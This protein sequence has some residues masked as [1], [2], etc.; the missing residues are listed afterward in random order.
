MNQY[1]SS[2]S[3]GY[4]S[5]DG[6]SGAASLPASTTDKIQ[7]PC[8]HCHAVLS[9][10]VGLS[11]FQCPRCSSHLSVDHAKLAAYMRSLNEMAASLGG[12]TMAA[13][14]TG[15]TAAAAAAAAAAESEQAKEAESGW[16][17]D[18]LLRRVH[19]YHGRG[20]GDG[21]VWA[22]GD[23]GGCRGGGSLAGLG[24]GMAGEGLRA[25]QAEVDAS[26]RRMMTGGR[27]GGPTAGEE[28]RQVEADAKEHSPLT[29]LFTAAAPSVLPTYPHPS[30]PPAL[31]TYPP[32]TPPIFSV[33]SWS[34]C[35]PPLFPS[36][37][38]PPLSPLLST[39]A[40]PTQCL[41][42][43]P[44]LLSPSSL[45][46]PLRL[47]LYPGR[48]A[49]DIDPSKLALLTGQDDHPPAPHPTLPLTFL[50]PSTLSFSS[51]P[52][53]SPTP[54]LPHLSP[55]H[56]PWSAHVAAAQA[57]AAGE[58]A[59]GVLLGTCGQW[60]RGAQWRGLYERT[61]TKAAAAHCE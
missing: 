18:A 19:T 34:L 10:P 54:H 45:S 57:A 40:S 35:F 22:R 58:R 3:Y 29:T 59:G 14:A 52:L 4:Q 17:R 15:A 41:G 48:A 33:P 53:L 11:R 1:P 32:H 16:V 31:T 43:K 55:S 47:S 2:G 37:P 27:A 50:L 7:L 25:A 60:A 13:A 6:A 26:L 8:A 46:A 23:W 38:A 12:A 44:T 28:A 21:L 39:C 61:G 20:W 30:H 51:P 5:A 36:L 9:V 42:I 56:P 49:P 24:G